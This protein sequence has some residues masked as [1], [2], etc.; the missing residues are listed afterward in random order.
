MVE[1]LLNFIEGIIVSYGATG[2]FWASFLEEVLAPIPS[3]LVIMTGGFFMLGNDPIS[4]TSFLKLFTQVVIP[5]SFGLTIGSLFAYFVFYFLGEPAINTFGKYFGITFADIE[6]IKERMSKGIMDDFFIFLSRAI[7]LFPVTIINVFCGLIRY[8]LLKFISISFL[9]VLFRA[10]ILGFLGWQL[11]AFHKE[12]SSQFE[13]VENFL[14]VLLVL[15]VLYFMYKNR[16]KSSETQ[17]K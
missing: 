9:G 13:K 6:K 15:G 8:P 16:E 1:N 14:A 10:T 12:I 5:V 11:G 4:F 7:P 2:I 17:S 3:S